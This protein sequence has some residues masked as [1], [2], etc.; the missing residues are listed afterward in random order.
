MQKQLKAAGGKHNYYSN[1]TVT[2]STTLS[3]VETYHGDAGATVVKR[4]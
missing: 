3:R 1:T 2:G 4:D